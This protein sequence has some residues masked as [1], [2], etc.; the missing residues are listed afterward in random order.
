MDI[1]RIKSILGIEDD[2]I[3]GQINAIASVTQERLSFLLGGVAEIPK[4]MAYI[5]DEV[6]IRRFNRIGSEGLSSHSVEGE[7]M[8][9]DD[10]DFAPYMADI[11]RY[12]ASDDNAHRN[13]RGVV[14]F[15]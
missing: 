12:L 3:D 5:A 11:E 4:D 9:W 6:T 10:D 8:T 13:G 1:T 15:I 14:R 2:H 7:A